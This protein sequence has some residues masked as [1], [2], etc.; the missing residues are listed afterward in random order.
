M[1]VPSELNVKNPEV[2]QS[3]VLSSESL[4]RGSL[5]TGELPRT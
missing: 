5:G 1:Y 2:S 3:R 4:L